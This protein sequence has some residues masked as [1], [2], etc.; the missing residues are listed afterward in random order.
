MQ[1]FGVRFTVSDRQ[2]FEALRSLFAEVKRD[3][4]CGTFRDPE[5]W[6]RLMPEAIKG[7]FSWPTAKERDS[8][9]SVRNVTLIA[10]PWPS[11]Q[12]GARWDFY[13]L[14][15]AIEESE[16]DPLRCEMQVEG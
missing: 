12:L 7:Q 9:L 1:A 2:R 16:Y 15:A 11:Q 13:R 10:V 6:T 8:W 3:K 5:Q 4:D 14:F